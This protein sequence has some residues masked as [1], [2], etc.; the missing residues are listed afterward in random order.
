MPND[1][2]TRRER[3]AESVLG[4][5]AIGLYQI[6]LAVALMALLFVIWPEVDADG[7]GW[8]R[9]LRWP[10]GGEISDDARLI[11]I[12]LCAGA[13]GSHVHAATSF[14]SY[15][16]N[17]SLKMSWAWW[18]V[19]RPFIGMSLA[20]IFYFVVR[21]GL[22]ATSAQSSEL[23]AFGVAAVAGLVGMFSKQATDKLRELFDSLFRTA[24]GE[25]DDARADKL[26]ANR[27]VT[28]HMVERRKMVACVIPQ[29]GDASQV[30]ITELHRRLGGIV[31]RVPV[32]R[33]D[34]VLVCVI[35][36]S[37]I[38]KFIAERGVAAAAGGTAFD[39]G[40]LTLADLL[41][42]PGMKELVQ[43]AVAYVSAGATLTDAKQLMER[44][45]NCQDVIVTEHGRPDEPLLGWLT[46]AD[47]R[48]A[49]TI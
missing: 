33:H 47:V 28:R 19:L 23:S 29:G 8:S 11:L 45:P 40:R 32:L 36:Q 7:K 2:S 27:P 24:R 42:E 12:V 5:L 30:R 13:L 6:V 34:D 41:A 31:T 9:S 14:A 39:P 3:P 10:A 44:T 25:G 38:Y 18:Y 49:A 16:G 37:L 46:D 15:V 20:L 22:L 48:R 26:A 21:G 43:D 17:R 4:M 1:P 35:H